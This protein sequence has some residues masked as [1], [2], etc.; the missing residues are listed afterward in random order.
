VENRIVTTSFFK[1]GLVTVLML[2]VIAFILGILVRQYE[3][4]ITQRIIA[5][6]AKAVQDSCGCR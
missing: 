3:A 1:D 4:H 6:T 5:E 2:L